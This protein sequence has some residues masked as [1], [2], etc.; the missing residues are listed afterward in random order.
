MSPSGLS[1]TGRRPYVAVI[2]SGAAN[3]EETHLAEAVG[4]ALGR[5]NAVLV[6][7]G[8]GG[9]MEAACRG[10]KGAGGTT[11]G[12]LPGADRNAANEY[13]DLA[14]STGVGESRNAII[15]ATADALIS[16]GGEYGT[17]SEIALALRAGK[18][19]VGLGT[20]KLLRPRVKPGA[21]P[22]ATPGASASDGI[23]EAT[24]PQDAVETALRLISC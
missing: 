1:P 2:G 15:V 14:V 19:V 20:W 13:V 17:L 8:L 3:Y 11:L 23:V 9:V 12:I 10:A 16:V 6:C 5:A 21:A 24:D 4:E 7:G 18:P 22:D